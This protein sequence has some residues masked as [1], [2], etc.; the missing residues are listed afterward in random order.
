MATCFIV[1]GKGIAGVAGSARPETGRSAATTLTGNRKMRLWLQ[2][3]QTHR[4]PKTV[5]WIMKKY[6]LLSEIR[7]RRKRAAPATGCRFGQSKAFRPAECDYLCGAV[8]FSGVFR[9]QTVLDSI[10]FFC[11]QFTSSHAFRFSE[12]SVF[13]QLSFYKQGLIFHV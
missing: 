3:G 6:S 12:A 11:R 5:L 4:N 8:L 9:R 1:K 10:P 7:R 13:K 2:R